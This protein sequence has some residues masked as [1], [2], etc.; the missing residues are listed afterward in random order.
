MM[1]FSTAQYSGVWFD[2]NGDRMMFRSQVQNY[3]REKLKDRAGTLEVRGDGPHW[4]GSIP[5]KGV[6]YAHTDHSGHKIGVLVFSESFEVGVD[7]E[8]LERV[9]HLN[10]ELIAE[11]F[12][13]EDEQVKASDPKQFLEIWVKKEAYAK[14]TRRG[15]VGTLKTSMDALEDAVL[16]S[17]PHSPP[18][19][20]A[21]I[22]LLN[23]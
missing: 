16:E 23:K 17:I 14:A 9:F 18:G 15:L 8:H 21:V 4:M 10:P 1:E 12:F 5:L 22:A 3:L 6:S 11:R 19:F 7:V 20:F 13:H 2:F